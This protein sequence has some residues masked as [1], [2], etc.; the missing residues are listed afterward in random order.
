MSS[1][2]QAIGLELAPGER[3]LWSGAPSKFRQPRWRVI[4][5]ILV[6]LIWVAFTVYAV[7]SP[8]R[9]G[10]TMPW[11]MAILFLIG[12]AWGIRGQFFMAALQRRNTAYGLTN[13]RAIIITQAFLRDRVVTSLPLDTLAE[14][15]LSER[16]DGSGSIRFGPATRSRS[17]SHISG[18]TWFGAPRSRIFDSIPEARTVYETIRDAQRRG[19]RAW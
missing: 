13:Q 6:Y 2:D 8:T 17:S 16:P 15:T 10:E 3:L 18:S 1:A 12:G 14:V 11:P 5:A 7:R 19:A 4:V 9:S